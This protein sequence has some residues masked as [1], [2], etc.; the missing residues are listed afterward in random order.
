MK[1]ESV[2][3]I[4]TNLLFVIG[5]ISTIF[6]FIKGT[7]TLS[8]VVMFENYP[9]N[10]YEESRCVYAI[11]VP[12]KPMPAPNDS[13]ERDYTQKENTKCMLELEHQKKVKK[14]DDVVVSITTLFSGIILILSFK[15]FIFK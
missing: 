11:S 8:K 14:A 15:K 5:V 6:G 4:F 1:I 10:Q 3:A 7:L 2:K 12:E 13:N 9:L